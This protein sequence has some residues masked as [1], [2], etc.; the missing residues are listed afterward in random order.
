LNKGGEEYRLHANDVRDDGTEEKGMECV[1]TGVFDAECW[2]QCDSCSRWRLL[3]RRCL[4]AI[5]EDVY[6]AVRPT[7]LDWESWLE[8]AGARYHA[9]GISA[10]HD[11][12]DEDVADGPTGL[13][14]PR[15]RLCVKTPSDAQH[16]A[17]LKVRLLMVPQGGA[18]CPGRL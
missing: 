13:E 17:L 8:N 4:P 16:P 6:M 7:D 10:T 14:V 15:K 5:N 1:A 3:D 2:R 9:A 11:G 18:G 12:Y